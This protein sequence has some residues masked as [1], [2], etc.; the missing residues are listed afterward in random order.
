MRFVLV[1]VVEELVPGQRARGIKCVSLSD[2]VLRDHFTWA[3]ILPG[4]MLIES[5]AQL[6]GALIEETAIAD[7]RAN[8]LA[9]LVGIDRARFR[10]GAKPGDRI[11][12]E[13]TVTSNKQIAATIT[14]RATIHGE[15][16]AEAELMFVVNRE[17]APELVAERARW[18]ALW[19]RGNAY[20]GD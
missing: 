4:T 8:D 9:V 1:D 17:A 13:A 12:L 16:A 3:P 6:G 11:E 20:R 15:L 5:L 7:G 10:R 2:D 19:R 14:A 18:R